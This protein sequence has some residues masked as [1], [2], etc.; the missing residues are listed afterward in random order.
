MDAA[1]DQRIS[2]CADI[3]RR[4][5]DI[6]NY[7][8]RANDSDPD[9]ERSLAVPVN[10]QPV[11]LTLWK[12]GS[13]SVIDQFGNGSIRIHPNNIPYIIDSDERVTFRAVQGA[14]ERLGE[15]EK[16]FHAAQSPTEQSNPA[17][18]QARG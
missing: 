10:G 2:L 7:A 15:I 4:V 14:I 1:I 5:L 17:D 8:P 18:A 16:A 12:T 3:R 11:A 6:L 13:I 9:I